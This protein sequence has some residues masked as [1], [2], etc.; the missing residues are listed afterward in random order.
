MLKEDEKGEDVTG[1]E[2]RN[3]GVEEEGLQRGKVDLYALRCGQVGAGVR[4]PAVTWFLPQTCV[5][6][7]SNKPICCRSDS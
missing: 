2:K 6:M 5:G 4:A 7:E 3:G 1:K